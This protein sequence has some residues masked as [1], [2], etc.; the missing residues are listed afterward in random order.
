ML[1]Q[2]DERLAGPQAVGGDLGGNGVR[3]GAA[4][5]QAGEQAPGQQRQAGQQD[6]AEPD[7]LLLPDGAGQ[8][9]ERQRAEQDERIRAGEQGQRGQGSR[10]RAPAGEGGV[11]AGGEQ[12]DV[13]AGFQAAHGKGDAVGR[14]R[15]QQ[16][17][18]NPGAL[19]A[20][21]PPKLPEQQ[22]GAGIRQGVDQHGQ[23]REGRIHAAGERAQGGHQAHVERGG[24]AQ[25]GLAGVEHR[26]KPRQ[27]VAR[28]AE[29]DVGVVDGARAGGEAGEEREEHDE[30][31]EEFHHGG[32]GR[33]I[34]PRRTRRH[35]GFSYGKEFHHGGHGPFRMLRE[36]TEIF[37]MGR[38]FT[39][40]PQRSQRS[41]RF[42][43]R[44]VRKRG[45][46]AGGYDR[47]E[48]L[49]VAPYQGRVAPYQGREAL[50]AGTLCAALP[51][52]ALVTRHSSLVPP[53][54][55]HSSLLTLHVLPAG[56]GWF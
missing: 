34:S 15:P 40:E 49:R 46:E 44:E 6:L 7:G 9:L 29:G 24:G 54:T 1:H 16:R 53:F 26:A 36:G 39:T 32:T 37:H 23:Q 5:G 28:V 35:G 52:G 50:L 42:F 41:Q 8:A 38:N 22:R 56:G 14:H 17:G 48:A 13:Q 2:A 19:R 10:Q 51:Q 4:V 30:G 21:A 11:G 33:K 47:W 45:G 18:G 12:Q 3:Q 25:H 20:Q 31:G 43:Y 55:P 27:Q